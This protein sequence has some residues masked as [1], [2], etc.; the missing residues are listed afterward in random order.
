M[1]DLADKANEHIELERAGQIAKR[2]PAGPVAT[3]RCLYC[4]D[5]TSDT[6]RWCSAEH[7][8]AW[9]REVDARL[10]RMAERS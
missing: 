9:Q 4:D 3:G 8:N 7:R 5:I 1:S 10:I 6:D 2:K